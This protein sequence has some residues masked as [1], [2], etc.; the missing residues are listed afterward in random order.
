[1]KLKL[2]VKV[3][4]IIILIISMVLIN[5]YYDNEYNK[6]IENNGYNCIALLN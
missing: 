2:W 3:C 4:L 5:N 1:M 6:C